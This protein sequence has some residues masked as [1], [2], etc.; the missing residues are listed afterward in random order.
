MQPLLRAVFSVHFIVYSIF[1]HTMP[2]AAEKR[3]NLS[4]LERVREIHRLIR[5][6]TENPLNKSLRATADILAQKLDVSDRQIRRDLEVL[7]RLLD[8]K[9]VERGFGGNECALKY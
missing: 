2:R 9:D 5:R 7:S 4:Q 3:S 1:Q 8:E 6:Y